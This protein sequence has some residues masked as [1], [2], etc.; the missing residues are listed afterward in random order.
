MQT[1]RLLLKKEARNS[2]NKQKI[3]LDI[4]TPRHRSMQV[5]ATDYMY[6]CII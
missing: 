1:A 3:F 2:C 6:L 5:R 4:K